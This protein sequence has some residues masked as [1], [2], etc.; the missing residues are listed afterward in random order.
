[1]VLEQYFLSPNWAWALLALIPLILLYLLKPK[2]KKQTIPSLMF[3]LQDAKKKRLQNFL[4]RFLP[5]L[6]LLL[7][8]LILLGLAAALMQPYIS[9]PVVSSAQNTVI[10]LDSSASMHAVDS[11][12]VRYE[13]AI[14]Q[15][16]PLLGSSNTIILAGVSA[17]IVV[18]EASA[19]EAQQFLRS[20]TPSHQPTR[21][22]VALQEAL[23]RVDENT[24]VL[25]ASDFIDTEVGNG[26]AEALGALRA[27][28]AQVVEVRVG[29]E[30]TNN[31][32]I[33]DVAATDTTTTITVQNFDE[34]TR[35][36][37]ACI[38]GT[39]REF[40]LEAQETQQWT[41]N[42]PAG[43]SE[44]RLSHEDAFSVDDVAYISS[45]EQRVLRVL[46]VTNSDWQSHELAQ[47]LAALSES[48]NLAVEVEIN[49]PPRLVDVNHDL[50]IFYEVGLSTVVERTFRDVES[51]VRAGDSAAIILYQQGLF[52]LPFG[53]LLAHEYE[54]VGGASAV[55][56]T[57]NQQRLVGLDYGYTPTHP[58]TR[59]TQQSL[60]L[61]TSQE[62]N[63]LITVT[64]LGAGRVLYYG[65]SGEAGFSATP[66][67]ALFFKE[68]IDYSLNRLSTSSRTL[69]TQTV[70]GG[71]GQARTPSGEVVSG[72]VAL[73][74]AGFYQTNQ[75]V[76]AA[77]LANAAES[78]IAVRASTQTS[79]SVGAEIVSSQPR[80]LSQWLIL[81]VLVLLLLELLYV[82]Y[83]GD[84]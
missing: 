31:I 22:R 61:A 23:T 43:T 62:E 73:F 67:Y 39:C 27:R 74:E 75:G 28:A 63:P 2:P 65:L 21:L 13:Q 72:R 11:S 54:G 49:T 56:N 70:L 14:T 19:R 48:T 66:D 45:E 64:N 24:V 46:V 3:F 7:Q 57:N 15:L 68:A 16:L 37:Q 9:V 29:E 25:I 38:A 69:R 50:I 83:R 33:V 58:I 40:V 20:W 41:F 34:Q 42:T 79:T 6:L 60:V 82:K 30:N 35:E 55:I 1:M 17:E 4:R 8:L 12:G 77:N 76:F 52:G 32:G 53:S 59:L 71:V 81:L 5:N 78:N 44:V 10:V 84:L 18:E 80:N 36:T 47:F 51:R 26:P